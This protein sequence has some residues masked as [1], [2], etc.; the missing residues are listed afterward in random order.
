M[1]N[2]RQNQSGGDDLSREIDAALDGVDLQAISSE[3]EERVQTTPGGDRLYMGVVAGVT[4]DDIIVE[5]GPR[6]QGVASVREFDEPPKVGDRMRFALRGREEGLWI[7]SRREAAS[8]A[9]WND[10][11]T[12]KLVKARVSGQNQGGLELKIGPHDAFM[13]ASQV[14]V[15]RVED[16]ST[17]IGETLVCE[18]LEIDKGRKR[19]VLSRRAVQSRERQDALTETVGKLHS[20]MV[21]RGKVTRIESFGAFIDIGQGVEGMLHVSNISRQRVEK[22]AD[23]LQVGQEFDVQVLE[24]KENGKRISLGKKQL[25]PDPWLDLA[26][27]LGVDTVH[28]G[29]VTKVMEFGAFVELE[30]GVEGLV[31]VSQLAKE[32][33]RR[34]QTAVKVGETFPVRVLA[35]DPAQER[36]SLS[37]LDTRGA[38]LG[39]E[40]SVDAGAIED[41]LDAHAERPL[42][43]TLGSLFKRALGGQPPKP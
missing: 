42:S 6:M 17:L 29:R 7:L 31:H 43:T 26:E 40:E 11:S 23:V 22:V 8:I 10:L 19:V 18:V 32:R 5:L 28:E 30:P 14:S 34:I 39:S 3:E 41:M 35:V 21:V 33:V 12:G 1:P 2:D 25:E 16:L 36:I 38:I 4:G 9:S 20:G 15:D 13:P 24:I 37:R 27:R